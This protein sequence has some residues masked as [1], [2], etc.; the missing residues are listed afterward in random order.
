[1]LVA[2]SASERSASEQHQYFGSESVTILVTWIIFLV[3]NRHHGATFGGWERWRI[4]S[5]IMSLAL[6]CFNFSMYLMVYLRRCTKARTCNLQVSPSL[7]ARF[8]SARELPDL[9][10]PNILPHWVNPNINV[11]EFQGKAACTE[12]TRILLANLKL[13]NH[14]QE[15]LL[16]I[17]C[18]VQAAGGV[19]LLLHLFPLAT[20]Y[21]LSNPWQSCMAPMKRCLSLL[22][23]L[24]RSGVCSTTILHLQPRSGPKI[25]KTFLHRAALQ[26][27]G[28]GII[29]F[30]LPTGCLCCTG[31]TYSALML[32]IS[33]SSSRAACFKAIRSL[34]FKNYCTTL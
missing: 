16:A 11:R 6:P 31:E 17:L 26:Q 20:L 22:P 29:R 8:S 27:D 15:A 32:I 2:E 4:K 24:L 18:S 12:L 25:S 23:S 21:W 9:Y 30:W 19:W 3:H 13:L 1:M 7:H 10:D 33:C 34:S 14:A 28:A 5:S